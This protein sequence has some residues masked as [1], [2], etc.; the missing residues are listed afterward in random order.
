MY[1]C[2]YVCVYVHIYIYIIVYIFINHN[3]IYV[4]IIDVNI[5]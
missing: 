1:V 3:I 2:I 4:N 5:T